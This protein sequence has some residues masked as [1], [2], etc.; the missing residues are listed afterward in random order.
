MYISTT[1][2]LIAVDMLFHASC[3][4]LHLSRE[5]SFLLRPINF[6][7][8]S[9]CT[10]STPNGIDLSVDA[11]EA[12]LWKPLVYYAPVANKYWP[13]LNI[14]ELTL[15]VDSTSIPI[16]APSTSGKTEV[17]FCAPGDAS[18][19]SFR[20]RQMNYGPEMTDQWILGDVE[21]RVE[22]EVVFQEEV[23]RYVGQSVWL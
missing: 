14:S 6:R 11:N 13:E 8:P 12:G 23:D 3:N 20:W 9:P 22:G 5:L 19:L 1:V 17:N 10:D 21:I 2:S 16:Q 4:L 15:A 18:S 7:Q